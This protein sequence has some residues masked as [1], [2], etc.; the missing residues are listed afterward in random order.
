M[1]SNDNQIDIELT[2][3]ISSGVY[4]NLAII[5]HSLGEFVTDFI[6]LMPGV[7][8]GKVQSRIIM[9]PLNAKRLVRALSENIHKY[10]QTFGE[11]EEAESHSRIKMN[12]GPPTTEA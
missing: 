6:Q 9:N 11:I 10:E 4:S 3:D 1:D 7:P 2:E 5:T 12:F 8:K